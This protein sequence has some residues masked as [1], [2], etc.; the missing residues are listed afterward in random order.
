MLEE[1]VKVAMFLPPGVAH[2]V[3]VQAARQGAGVSE[4]VGNMF[5]CAHCREPIID[6]FIVGAPKLIAP[7][8][9]AV[10]FHK[11]RAACLAASGTRINFFVDCPN[12]K[13][14]PHQSFDRT[15]LPR[16]LKTKGVKFYCISCDHSWQA[17]TK[18]LEEI[19][20]ISC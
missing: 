13:A 16:L 2:A 17:T 19:A 3:K 10:F 8:K 5:M 11:N 18:E 4:L 14:K 7:N 15:E 12:C 20:R 9:Y 1:K 6:E